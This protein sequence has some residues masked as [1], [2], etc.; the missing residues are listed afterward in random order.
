MDPEQ[1]AAQTAALMMQN[2][3]SIVA[4]L[5]F[6]KDQIENLNEEEW[7]AIGMVG[8]AMGLPD[9][10]MPLV[11]GMYF[12]N[13]DYIITAL[14]RINDEKYSYALYET[15][16]GARETKKRCRLVLWAILDTKLKKRIANIA[17]DDENK[18]AMITDA[19]FHNPTLFK[20]MEETYLYIAS[21]AKLWCVNKTIADMKG[22]KKFHNET[23]MLLAN[24]GFAS[25]GRGRVFVTI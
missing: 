21:M 1:E 2:A 17:R 7:Q 10:E 13:R 4:K 5:V 3:P 23:M 18:I 22:P 19:Y 14:S 20:R 24:T 9:E 25:M 11:L 15:A 12:S 6:H 8:C 16:Q